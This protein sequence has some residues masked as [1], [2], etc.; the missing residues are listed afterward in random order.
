MVSVVSKKALGAPDA[1][2]RWCQCAG[3]LG[4]MISHEVKTNPRYNEFDLT[5]LR[6]R[7]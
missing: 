2:K 6:R 5:T 3:E 7:K 4:D 1:R